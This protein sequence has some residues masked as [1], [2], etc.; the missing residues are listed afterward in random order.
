M[1]MY[2]NHNVSGAQTYCGLC[3]RYRR[4]K[5]T[6]ICYKQASNVFSLLTFITD[7]VSNNKGFRMCVKIH[8]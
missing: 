6:A 5:V 3:S 2:E 7:I 4:A 8:L 1:H